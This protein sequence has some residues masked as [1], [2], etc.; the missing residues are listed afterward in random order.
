MTDVVQKKETRI[1][2]DGRECTTP[3]MD[4]ETPGEGKEA[5]EMLIRQFN[6]DANLTVLLIQSP[7]ARRKTVAG[8]SHLLPHNDPP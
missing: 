5:K 3:T 6:L 1:I 8:K 7:E 2:G 4:T